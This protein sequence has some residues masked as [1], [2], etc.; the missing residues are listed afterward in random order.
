MTWDK[1]IASTCRY[2]EVAGH[3][4][5]DWEVIWED[6]TSD[7]QG[8]AS[9][10]A[11]KG[12]RYCFYEWWYGSCSG[13]DGWEADGKSDDDIEHEMR[14]MALWMPSE[15]ALRKW[16]MMLEGKSPLSNYSMERGGG[17]SSGIDILSG[18]LLDRIN[19]IR[20]HF[21]MEPYKPKEPTP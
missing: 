14:D 7:Y 11:K 9:F 6:S 4:W 19:A 8:H 10:I 13:C 2:G 15:A 20:A 17:L 21:G 3:I 16:L 12:K 5:G 18:G 1:T